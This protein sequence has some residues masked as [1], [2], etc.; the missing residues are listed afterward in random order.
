MEEMLAKFLVS[1]SVRYEDVGGLS[2]TL[3]QL[4][5]M[6]EWPIQHTT[7]FEWL[8]VSPPKGILISGPP[9]SGKT[10]VAMAVAG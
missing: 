6:I 7:I 1:S 3:K 2:D 9:G 4:R 10:L 8:G 5:E